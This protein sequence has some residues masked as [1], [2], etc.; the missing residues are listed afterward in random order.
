MTIIDFPFNNNNALFKFKQQITGQTGN[1]GTK[2]VEIMILLK[3]LSKFWR[4]I[5]MPLIAKLV[6]S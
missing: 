2:V 3:Y 4:T 5:E 1:C 6:F